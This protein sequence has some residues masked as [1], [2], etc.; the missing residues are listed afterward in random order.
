MVQW[1]DYPFPVGGSRFES[2]GTLTNLRIV[3]YEFIAPSVTSV[4]KT[5]PSYKQTNTQ[6]HKRA[7]KMSLWPMFFQDSC[8]VPQ[9]LAW[10]TNSTQPVQW[11]AGDRIMND[12][13]QDTWWNME[14]MGM[15]A[16]CTWKTSVYKQIPN[17][18]VHEKSLSGSVDWSP[19]SCWWLEVRVHGNSH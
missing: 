15:S 8:I 14:F 16:I 5:Q 19:F 4:Q 10:P 9:K 13:C 17:S 6:T 2:T 1:T 11:M 7:H 18:T 12:A 3:H